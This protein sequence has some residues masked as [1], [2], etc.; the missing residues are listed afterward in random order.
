[1]Y[2]EIKEKTISMK[3]CYDIFSAIN[4]RQIEALMFHDQMADYFG[5]LAYAGYKEMHEYQY[6]S[7]SLEHRKT[8]KYFMKKHNRILKDEVTNPK[9]VPVEWFS[10]ERNEATDSVKVKG[11]RDGMMAYHAW[12]KETLE[13][14]EKCASLAMK[15]GKI[16][17]Y[18]Y[19][20]CLIKDTSDEIERIEKIVLDLISVD[21]DVVYILEAQDCLHKMYKDKLNEIFD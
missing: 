18:E 4:K 7:E 14:Y 12:E 9:A 21:Y 10:R 1:M 3:T 17:D 8:K 20:T 19:I 2:D 5:F 6:I 16:C 13:L 15:M 11:V